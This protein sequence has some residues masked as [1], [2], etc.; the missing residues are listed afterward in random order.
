MLWAL[1]TTSRLLGSG[2][3]PLPFVASGT[4]T[5]IRLDGRP[6]QARGTLPTSNKIIAE[7]LTIVSAFKFGTSK[8]ATTR[9]PRRLPA[10]DVA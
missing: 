4:S 8:K 1:S 10:L 3:E 5:R 2:G 7:K 6:L 9:V